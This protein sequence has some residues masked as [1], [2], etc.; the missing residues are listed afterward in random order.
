MTSEGDPLVTRLEAV[1][2]DVDAV[3]RE[4]L[5]VAVRAQ[6]LGEPAA[7]T[8]IDRFTVLETLGAGGMGV[9]YGAY[10]P[11]LDRKVAIKLV[12]PWQGGRAEV[13][14]ERLTREARALA[15]LSHPNVVAVYEVGLHDD[16]V[17]VA[18]EF[19]RGRTLTR[20]GVANGTPWREVL[21]LYLQAAEG[22]AAA[23][24]AG[25]VHR[26]FKPDNAIVGDDGRVRVLDFG[27]ARDAGSA[28]A[29]GASPDARTTSSSGLTVAGAVIGTPA[30]MAPEQRLGLPA[31]GA[32]DQFAWCASLHEALGGGLPVVDDGD[33]RV[34]LP[35]WLPTRAR[36]ALVRGLA[37]LPAQ[38][39]ADL[40][41]LVRALRSVLERPRWTRLSVAAALIAGGLAGAVTVTSMGDEPCVDPTPELA[42]VWDDRRRVELREAADRF[43]AL[44][45]TAAEIV[46]AELDRRAAEWTGARLEACEARWVRRSDGESTFALRTRCLDRRRSELGS[47]VDALSGGDA[48]A[49]RRAVEA[50]VAL[51]PVT[52]CDGAER[53]SAVAPTDVA[54][55]DG[56][57]VRIDR[58]HTLE[59][60]GALAQGRAEIDA[61]VDD[62]LALGH[63]PTE[64]EALRAKALLVASE[65]RDAE[66]IPV[67]VDALWRAEAGRADEL[68]LDVMAKLL[69]LTADSGDLAHADELAL[70][71]RGATERLGRRSAVE[72]QVLRA[73]HTLALAHS[74][75]VQAEALARESL[76]LSRAWRGEDALD[77]GRDLNNV[78]TTQYERGELAAARSRSRPPRDQAALAGR[79][80]SRRRRGPHE[81][82]QRRRARGTRRA[83]P[84][85]AGG[86]HRRRRRHRVGQ[87]VARR[88]AGQPRELAPQRRAAAQALLLAQRSLAVLEAT[89]G[90]DDAALL[91]TLVVL[92]IAYGEAGQVELE[93]ACYERAYALAD[94][95]DPGASAQGDR[96]QQPRG[97][98][99]RSRRPRGRTHEAGRGHRAVEPQQRRRASDH[100]QPDVRVGRRRARARPG[101]IGGHPRPAGGRGVGRGARPRTRRRSRRPSCRW[102]GR[103]SASRAARP[104]RPCRPPLRPRTASR[105]WRTRPGRP[106]RGN[107]SRATLF[108]DQTGPGPVL[109]GTEGSA[110]C[111]HSASRLPS[112]C[113]RSPPRVPPRAATPAWP[114]ASSPPTASASTSSRPLPG[115]QRPARGRARGRAAHGRVGLGRD[116]ARG[117]RRR[118]RA[119]HPRVHGLVRPG[120]RSEPRGRGVRRDPEL[121]GRPGTRTRVGPGRRPLR[122][123]L[124]RMG[125]RVPGRPHQFPRRVAAD[126]AAG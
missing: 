120:S 16:S 99:S 121:C 95:I 22:L 74:D 114:I 47:L 8:R 86:H 103:S 59:R 52:D 102:H 54:A 80:P 115:R 71:V 82:R 63:R 85:R 42:G 105:R 79:G 87:S 126:L 117:R 20:T 48:E 50:T 94:R 11:Q 90:P 18:M 106:R 23:H 123:G 21:A 92:G 28:D 78:G 97:A 101:G 109:G 31:T 81:P 29:V 53:S 10:D 25:L 110:P 60:L 68:A 24:D 93:R 56:L 1:R 6:V 19:V 5:R 65:S 67:Y 76:E 91:E 12:R 118:A 107:S 64:A 70:R 39:H 84:G 122:R 58:I 111:N 44:A 7:E 2:I 3:E 55:A 46:V 13:E 14:R 72:I 45:R 34:S 15:K 17:F 37:Y 119:R 51:S 112:C 108:R 27:L 61:V 98:R 88:R 4:R 89:L 100:R 96:A 124:S 83:R 73:R 35:V 26:D 40:R 62:A 38:R 75:F 33:V 125:Q 36:R 104:P 43:D 69:A 9:V 49:W 30:Y 66:A 57:A 77:V 116:H 41:Q 32:S 113:S